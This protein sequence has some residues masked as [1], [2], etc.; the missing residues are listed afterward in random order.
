MPVASGDEVLRFSADLIRTTQDDRKPASARPLEAVDHEVLAGYET[1]LA[2]GEEG[3]QLGDIGGLAE[4]VEHDAL[5]ELRSARLGQ[6]VA[7]LGLDHAGTDGIDG[8]LGA[9]LLC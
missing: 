4:A 1:R 9:E 3:N 6:A 8:D 5:G 7:Q 2:G